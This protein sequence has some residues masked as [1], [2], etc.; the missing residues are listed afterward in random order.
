VPLL[1]SLVA[2]F[3]LVCAVTNRWRDGVQERSDTMSGYEGESIL[4]EHGWFVT[5]FLR[6]QLS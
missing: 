4:G 5:A 1:Q 6:W 2:A 3:G